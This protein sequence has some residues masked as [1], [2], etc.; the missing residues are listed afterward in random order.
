VWSFLGDMADARKFVFLGFSVFFRPRS[1]TMLLLNSSQ[2]G[3][4]MAVV[5][6]PGHYQYECAMYVR[7][8]T[9]TT[10]RKQNRIEQMGDMLD[11]AMH[12]ANVACWREI[13]A[14]LRADS[15]N[16]SPWKEGKR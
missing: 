2:F 10:F 14:P 9:E 4:Y 12:Q 15:K 11:S 6:N 1:G 16:A 8:S 13:T 3:H 5:I 7:W